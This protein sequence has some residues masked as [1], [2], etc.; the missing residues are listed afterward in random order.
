MGG[1]KTKYAVDLN[2]DQI[3]W[4]QEISKKYAISDE[5][6]ALRIILD[7]IQDEA[8]LDTVFGQVR[9]NHCG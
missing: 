5:G 1:I 2:A 3:S 8:D 7:Y 9:C 6:K 4:L